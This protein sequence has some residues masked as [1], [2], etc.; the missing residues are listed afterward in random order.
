[1]FLRLHQVNRLRLRRRG[2]TVVR[3]GAHAV[4]NW[5]QRTPRWW[6]DS[7]LQITIENW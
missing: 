5:E 6:P 2:T 3:V 1:M 4:E 7:M